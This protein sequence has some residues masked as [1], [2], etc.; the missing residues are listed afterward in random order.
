ME[1]VMG[2]AKAAAAQ[3]V[4]LFLA[5]MI[6]GRLSV[7]R[8]V[9]RITPTTMVLL[10]VLTASVG[11]LL[12]WQGQTAVVGLAGLVV[13]GLGVAGLY[14]LLL[15]LAL[16]A[17]AGNTVQASARA[18]LASGTAI[19]TLPLVLGRL[20]DA[21]GIHTAY[22]VVILLLITLLAIALFTRRWR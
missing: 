6:V 2:L 21:V 8:L 13:T 1:T 18:T 9:Q 16:A 22:G 17:A 20:A 12:Y 19:L 4:S 7:S 5:A 14:P 15:S 11:F 10:S 3:S